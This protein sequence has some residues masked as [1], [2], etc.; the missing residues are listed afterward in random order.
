MNF[1]THYNMRDVV[2]PG[3]TNTSP[4]QT[5]PGQSMSVLDLYDRW[6]SGRSISGVK[7]PEYD[8]DGT[9]KVPLDFDDYM[10]NLD[11]LDMADRQAILEE[12]KEQLDD[13]KK[14]LDAIAASKKR[15]Q[16]LKEAQWKKRIEKLEAAEKAKETSA[17]KPSR[18]E[19]NG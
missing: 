10:P 9:G 1:K 4:S 16:E 7:S 3:E 19:D 11:K 5:I 2:S 12:A 17:G 13:V 8:D 6:R 18:T 15:N 14:R